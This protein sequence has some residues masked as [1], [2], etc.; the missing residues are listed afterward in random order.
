MKS[1]LYDF[2]M[3]GP[4]RVFDLPFVVVL[5]MLCHNK[6]STSVRSPHSSLQSR[7]PDT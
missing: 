3:T 7:T 2:H 6:E 1:D 5:I 4:F